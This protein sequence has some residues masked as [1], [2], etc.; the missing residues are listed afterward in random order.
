MEAVRL[1]F[2][3][4]KLNGLKVCAGDVGNAFLHGKT[5][6]KLFIVAG[7]EFGPELAGKRLIIDK[8]LYGLKRSAATYHEHLS[9]TLRKMGFRPSKADADLWMKKCSDGHYEYIAWYVDDVI[10]F[11]KDPMAIMKKLKETSSK[12]AQSVATEPDI[13]WQ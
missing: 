3:M 1:G 11:S 5:R 13:L 10:A 7:P 9:E 6:E 8:S 4:A 2:L 12:T